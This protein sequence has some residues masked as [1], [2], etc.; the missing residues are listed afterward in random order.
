MAYDS[1][2]ARVVLF[3]GYNGSQLGDTWEWDGA[4]WAQRATSGPSPRDSHAMVYESAHGRVVLF[5][6]YGT[7]Y[8]GDTWEWDGTAWTQRATSGPSPRSNHAM[9][10]DSARGRVVLFGGLRGPTNLL[11][12]SWEWDGMT[13]T[14][15]A[16]SGPSPRDGHAMAYDSARDRAVLFGGSGGSGS[17][18]DTWEYGVPAICPTI[19]ADPTPALACPDGSALFAVAA[20]GSAPLSY[21][22]QIQLP[23]GAWQALGNDPGPIT[24]QDSGSGFAFA[25]PINSPSVNIGVHGCPGVQHWPVRCIVSNICGSATSAQATLTIC[26]A[27]FNC[28]GALDSQDFFDFLTAFFAAA[29]GADFNGDGAINSQDFFDF[30]TAFFAGCA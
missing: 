23:S 11:G 1:A 21:Q 9:A 8:L 10:Y 14:Q 5:G 12:D 20:S 3:G 26:P 7:T 28:S 6:G 22:W 24:C 18:G 25:T 13:W 17:L 4:T 19:D 29:P 27:D 2:R 16:V 30:L 15:Q